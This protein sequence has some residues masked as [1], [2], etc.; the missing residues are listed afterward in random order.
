MTSDTERHLRGLISVAEIVEE[1][2]KNI[3][4]NDDVD[5]VTEEALNHLYKLKEV[6][7]RGANG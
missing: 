4:R 6:L 1:T 2:L 7:E 3:G 5:D